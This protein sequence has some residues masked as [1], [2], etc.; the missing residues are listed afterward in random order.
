VAD[1]GRGAPAGPPIEAGVGRQI[2]GSGVSG[3]STGPVDPR[4]IAPPGIPD[5]PVR[6]RARDPNALVN[7]WVGT[8]W[9]SVAKVEAEYM[10]AAVMEESLGDKLGGRA[11]S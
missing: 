4:L 3:L 6:A 8:Y 10:N 11:M 7:S 5:G 9:D 1:T 2:F